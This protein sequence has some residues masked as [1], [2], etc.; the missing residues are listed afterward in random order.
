MDNIAP[1]Q[2]DKSIVARLVEIFGERHVSVT[3]VDRAAYSRDLW[4]RTHIWM[5]GG[6]IPHPPDAVV[7]AKN[8]EQ[9]AELLKL[10]NKELFPVIPYGAGSG[11]CGGALPLFRGV[12]LD[13]K[14]M[15]RIIEIDDVSLT[16]T[17][18]PGVIG[19]HLE[20]ELNR[21]GYTMGHFPSS[22][23][24]S[25][26]GGYLAARS[27]GQLSARYGKIEDMVMSL[28]AV[29][30]NGDIAETVCSPRSAAG[31]NWT[32]MFVGSEGTLGVITRAR[33]RIYPY[34]PSRLFRAFTFNGV[35]DALESIREIMR[36]GVLP[37]AVRLYDE[38]D[39]I[40]IGGKK[41]D[42]VETPINHDPEPE[43]PVK[44]V[45]HE[46]S[47][48]VQNILMGIP[49]VA[50]RLAEHVKG[51]CL[52][53]LTFEGVPEMTNAELETSVRICKKNSGRDEGEE[54]AKRWW[55]NRYNVSYNQ[56]RVFHQG[57]WVD[58]FEVATTWDKV[59]KLYFAVRKAVSPH[60]FIMAHFSHAYVHGCCIYFSMLSRGRDQEE[61]EKVY[62][63]VWKAAQGTAVRFG[64]TVTHHHGVGL[65]KAQGLKRELGPLM[66]TFR[67]V[68]T[69]M[70][71][72]NILNPG[73]LGLPDWGE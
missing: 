46:V 47:S 19:Q 52:L 56:S 63:T 71:P 43:N 62:D 73:K 29:L 24:C 6:R 69:V 68:K 28:R 39:T 58:T 50:G 31:P 38:L 54:P 1:S 34:P 33:M 14:K 30:P 10:A 3:A 40:L 72:N 32:Q 12:I 37:A 18:E 9:I 21:K 48:G 51:K 41:E 20:M 26:L 2:L 59:E 13:V 23:Y 53:V 7:W 66:E 44:K 8:E 64:A 15:D 36:A 42:S 25:S 22:I 61:A 4:P 65:H 67:G 27:A 16:V 60:A 49:K 70:D 17:A 55:E 45:M 11:V 57:S 5:S 35:H